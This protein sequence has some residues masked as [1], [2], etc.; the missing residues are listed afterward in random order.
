MSPIYV[1]CITHRLKC[2]KTNAKGQ[3]KVYGINRKSVKPKYVCKQ[4]LD[5]VGSKIIIF[6]NPKNG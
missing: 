3:H 5:G 2:I 1:N 6:K 4:T